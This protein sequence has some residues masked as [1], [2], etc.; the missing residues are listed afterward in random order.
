[1]NNPTR[2]QGA[3]QA[4]I[5]IIELLISLVISMAVVAGA[6]QVVASS[7]RNFMDQDEV[8]FIQT[9][10][11]YAL[12]LIAKDVRMAGYAGCAT[13]TAMDI[14]N[15]LTSNFDGY[16]SLHG[17]RGFEGELN[18]NAFP[19]DFK[20]QVKTDTDAILIRR[21]SDE[22]ELDVKH[23]NASAATID[24]WQGHDYDNG[25]V[26]MIAD[27]SCRH[28]GLF[29]A[30][31]ANPSRIAHAMGGVT[32]NC[33]TVIKGNFACDG[34]CTATKCGDAEAAT[35]NY[36]VGSKVMG[37]IAHAYFIAESSVLPGMPALKRQ[38][39]AKSGA[40]VTVT[41]ELAVGVEDMQILYGVDSDSD[42][43]VD[44]FRK[45]SD[46]DLN[47][48]GHISDAEWDQVMSVKVSL[49]FRSQNP[50]LPKPQAKTFAG[51][52]YN[53]R[54]MRQVVNSTLRI[55]NRG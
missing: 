27:A 20:D 2:V 24:F 35:G 36:G 38:A 55:R 33:T 46:M 5:S 6:V 13:K 37:F 42:G 25:S 14:A 52:D 34:S 17:L 19:A 40:P 50:V 18:N 7:K 31:G 16:V 29:Q 8:T 54:F 39:L 44:Q 26:L 1:M 4:G 47:G 21:A 51:K 10:A 48:D 32:E 41:Q 28:V 45:A 3:R 9:N 15:S 30:S 23:H 49:V 43:A 11:R 22:N 53:D 12:D